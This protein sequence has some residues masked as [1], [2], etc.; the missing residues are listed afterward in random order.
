[1]ESVGERQE[2]EG[3][4]GAKEGVKEWGK[5]WRK[6]LPTTER[7]A[8]FGEQQVRA[9]VARATLAPFDLQRGPLFRVQVYRLAEDDW[10]V[11]AM[12]HHIVVDFWSLVIIVDEM[13]AAYP[14]FAQQRARSCRRRRITLLSSC[15][16]NS[17]CWPAHAGTNCVIT[18]KRPW[19]GRLA[20]SIFPAIACGQLCL[21]TRRAV[22][23]SNSQ[24]ALPRT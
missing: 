22:H 2:G 3:G 15:V 1:M 21:R 20:C 13:R 6:E 19:L 14:C 24:R 12:T 7:R 17:C 9:A 16:I 8:T 4:A 18:G 10:I 11:L 5:E 23:L